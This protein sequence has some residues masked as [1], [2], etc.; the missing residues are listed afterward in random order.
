M[1]HSVRGGVYPSM[2]LDREGCLPGG[3]VVGEFKGALTRS[4][5]ILLECILVLFLMQICG[6]AGPLL[7]GELSGVKSRFSAIFRNF[8][9]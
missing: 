2:H 6:L 7:T 4:I 8:P 5:R 9:T 3:G 1:C